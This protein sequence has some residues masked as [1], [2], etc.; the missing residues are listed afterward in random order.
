MSDRKKWFGGVAVA[1]C[2]AVGTVGV[3]VAGAGA[4]AG[5]G[6]SPVP[7]ALTA[8][9]EPVAAIDPKQAEAIGQLRRSRTTDDALP[10]SWAEELTDGENGPGHWGANPSLSRRTA[11]GVWVVPGDGYVCLANSTP[12]SGG[13]GFGCATMEDLGRGL[14]APSDVDANGN[15]ILTGVLPDGVDRV[16]LVDLDGSSRTAEVE[17][18]TYRAAIDAE[19]KEV[20]FTSPDGARRVL[21]MAWSR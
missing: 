12:D 4:D 3:I 7:E 19:L 10:T 5:L 11:P 8:D 13:M 2:L 14:L 9:R 20:R 17:R 15:G 1:T 21:P 18:N 16:T 6:R